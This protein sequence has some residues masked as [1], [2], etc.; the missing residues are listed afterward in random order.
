MS[1]V[2]FSTSAGVSIVAQPPSAS[3][4]VLRATTALPNF[5]SPDAIYGVSGGAPTTESLTSALSGTIEIQTTNAY[6]SLTQ[7]VLGSAAEGVITAM[8]PGVAAVGDIRCDTNPSDGATLAVGIGATSSGYRFKNTLAAAYDVKI[9]ATPALTMANFKAAINADGTPGTEY[10]AGTAA[11]PLVSATVSTDV[12]TITDR[13]PCD[14]QLEWS[15][16]ESASNF[17]KRIPM[18]GID[19]ATLFTIPAGSYGAAVS[20]TFSNEAR[21]TATLPAKM[22]AVSGYVP[23]NG[24]AAMYRIYTSDDLKV[25][26][27]YST[28]LLTWRD[29]SEGELT[30]SAGETH[31]TFA[32]L[33]EYLR[34]CVT[35]N[36]NST[37]TILDARVTY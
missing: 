18:G 15:I 19:G 16:T 23:T 11:N 20:L 2:A 1:N 21:D 17:S 33:H 10:H 9:G 28:D 8:L 6:T 13:V 37:N 34:F 3:K 14:R 5:S 36:A 26:F 35:E 27:Q 29:T 12:V 7:L 30:L 31:A 4:I 22:L 32:E 25:K 24:A